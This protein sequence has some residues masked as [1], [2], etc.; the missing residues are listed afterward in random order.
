[1]FFAGGGAKSPWYRNA[2]Q[3]I[4]A[5]GLSGLKA[6]TVTKPV[7][8]RGDDFP[9]FVIALG[10]ADMPEAMVDAMLPRS[11]PIKGP[12]PT[13]VVHPPLYEGR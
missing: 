9:R 6:E 5:D 12:L 11:I 2:I 3:G 7:D 8:Y 13:R 4:G 1:M 10:L